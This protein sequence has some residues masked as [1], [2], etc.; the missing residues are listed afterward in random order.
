[1]KHYDYKKAKSIIKENKN[2]LVEAELGMIEDWY[3]TAETIWENGKYLKKLNNE[4]EIGGISA[5]TWAT[6][7]LKLTFS[8]NTEITCNCYK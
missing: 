5:S 2:N 3:W 4:T 1:M 6:P 8:D 7:K